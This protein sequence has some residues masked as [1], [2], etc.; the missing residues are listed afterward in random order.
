MRW[1]YEFSHEKQLHDISTVK[2]EAMLIRAVNPDHLRR[3]W[4]L[5][6]ELTA[7]RCGG[8]K[9]RAVLGRLL[10]DA[11]VEDLILHI[12]VLQNRLQPGES[13]DFDEAAKE[14]QL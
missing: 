4:E 8:E 2:G 13:I 11:N 14:I 7:P 6:P 9:T 1:H 5:F 12:A 10:P 3:A